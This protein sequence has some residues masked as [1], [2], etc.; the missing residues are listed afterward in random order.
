MTTRPN[1]ETPGIRYHII[2]YDCRLKHC[3][4]SIPS[5][6]ACG[7][8]T[9]VQPRWLR[10]LGRLLRPQLFSDT[11]LASTCSNDFKMDSMRTIAQH[12]HPQPRDSCLISC[13]HVELPLR[14]LAAAALCCNPA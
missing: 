12:Q 11:V 2:S 1:D 3:K 9:E 14:G 6:L 7:V 10:G 5:V 8:R 4:D 13:Q